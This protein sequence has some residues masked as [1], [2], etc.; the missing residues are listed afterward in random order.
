MKMTVVCDLA[1]EP[2]IL[3]SALDMRRACRP[4][5][6]SPMSPSSSALGTSAATESTTTMST[7]EERTSWS[8]TSSAISP[9]SGLT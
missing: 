5:C 4:I 6:M 2:V 8:T 7:A 3:R 1:S 9:E